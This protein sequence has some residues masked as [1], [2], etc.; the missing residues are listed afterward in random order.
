MTDD[1]IEKLLRDAMPGLWRY[2]PDPDHDDWGT[3]REPDGSIIV[4]VRGTTIPASEFDQHRRSGTDPYEA[5]AR[6]I[7][8][9]PDLAKEVL[10]LRAL[11]PKEGS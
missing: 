11:L 10:R 6:L 9:A 1:E 3:V 7:A 5:N 2:R 4:L 8:A